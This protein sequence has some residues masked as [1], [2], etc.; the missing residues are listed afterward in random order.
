MVMEM[1][2]LMM[3]MMPKPPR[4]LVVVKIVREYATCI[5]EGPKGTIY[6]TCTRGKYARNPLI[7][8]ETTM[9]KYRSK[10]DRCPSTSFPSRS[11]LGVRFLRVLL[12]TN[13]GSVF[14]LQGVKVFDKAVLMAHGT[15]GPYDW[16][17][18]YQCS[19]KHL[20]PPFSMDSLLGARINVIKA[21][22]ASNQHIF[23]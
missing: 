13:V 2:H 19:L 5:L 7:V 17:Q 23:V 11:P 20:S 9:Y 14:R 22:M 12:C 8:K 21:L 6:S 4:I 15:S 1:Q 3:E 16:P 10:K 18:P